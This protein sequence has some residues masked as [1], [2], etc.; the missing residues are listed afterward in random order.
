MVPT[1]V[2]RQRYVTNGSIVPTVTHHQEA[3]Q[4]PQKTGD[5]N[6]SDVDLLLYYLLLILRL[7]GIWRP[8]LLAR[9]CLYTWYEVRTVLKLGLGSTKWWTARIK[10]FLAT[11]GFPELS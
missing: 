5:Q 8:H 1:V 11:R 9:V 2:C 7:K 3:R 4:G 6:V 10:L